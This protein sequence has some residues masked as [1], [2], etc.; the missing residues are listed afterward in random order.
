MW[1]NRP[2]GN[3][4]G[5]RYLEVRTWKLCRDV[6]KN[7]ERTE[8]NF[9]LVL[10]F[11]DWLD[12]KRLP[13]ASYRAFIF[14][15]L[16]AIDK[17]PD[18]FPVIVGETWRR[19]FAK[20]VLRVTEPKLSIACQDDQLCAG[21]K[22]VIDGAVHGVQSIWETKLTTKDWVFLL[23]DFKK[24]LSLFPCLTTMATSTYCYFPGFVGASG[25]LML[26]LLGRVRR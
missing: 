11:F 16:I 10:K 1:T 5:V 6:F 22:V 20:C 3:F 26:N 23:V 8:K 15:R 14:V 7:L 19:L 21:L 9:I 2:H 12:N 25:S 18:F 4:H 13:W 24:P 17:E